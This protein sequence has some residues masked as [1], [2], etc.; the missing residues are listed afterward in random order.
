MKFVHTALALLLVV[1]SSQAKDGPHIT[2][3]ET[4]CATTA[5]LSGNVGCEVDDSCDICDV[6]EYFDATTG[7]THMYCYCKSGQFSSICC[8][9]HYGTE[10][11]GGTSVTAIGSCKGVCGPAP[12]GCAI[13]FEGVWYASCEGL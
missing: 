6:G 2:H 8:N 12:A 9:L 13:Y 7:F 11:G 1:A 10:P 4:I 3:A 5:T